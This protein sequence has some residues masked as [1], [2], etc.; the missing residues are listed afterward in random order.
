VDNN[1]REFDTDTQMTIY[2]GRRR[3]KFSVEAM[4]HMTLLAYC[5][6]NEYLNVYVI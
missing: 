5:I 1:K 4:S 6:F 2:T 3:H